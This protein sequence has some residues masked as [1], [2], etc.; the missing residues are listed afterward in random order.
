M[1]GFEGTEGRPKR[2]TR[3]TV[4]NAGSPKSREAQGDGAAIVVRERESRL[5]GEG[6]YGIVESQR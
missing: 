2:A 5:Q 1:K 3:S 4:V 6:R